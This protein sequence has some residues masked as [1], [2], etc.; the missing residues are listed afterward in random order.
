M[1]RVGKSPI[2]VP[3]GVELNVA[4]E[5]VKVKGP[6]GELT[7]PLPK[8]LTLETENGLATLTLSDES[9]R[10]KSMFGTSR[11]LLANCVE[12]VSKGWSKRLEL[13]GVGY[14]AQLKG[15]ELVFS[16]GYSHEVRYPLPS[17]V[18]AQVTDQTKIDLNSIDKQKLGQVA[19]EI[20]AL[21]PPEPYKGKGVRYSDETV[22]RKAGKAGKAGKK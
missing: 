5:V 10:L 6:L 20:R 13:L 21:R 11:A 1:S 3:G 19:A 9:G 22:R 8:G 7:A 14:R 18:K 12:G 2:T 17:D 4:G 15:S 16:L